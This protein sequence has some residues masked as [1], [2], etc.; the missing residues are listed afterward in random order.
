M[1]PWAVGLCPG[2]LITRKWWMAGSKSFV[3]FLSR[4]PL[5][6]TSADHQ[7]RP[8]SWVLCSELSKGQK[9]KKKEGKTNEKKMIQIKGTGFLYHVRLKSQNHWRER[10]AG[11]IKMEHC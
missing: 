11:P 9:K 10:V 4:Y 2:A 5:L 1:K 6:C 8:E 7:K 3:G